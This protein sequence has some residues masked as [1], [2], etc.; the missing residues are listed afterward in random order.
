MNRRLKKDLRISV[1]TLIVTVI[2]STAVFNCIEFFFEKLDT[3]QPTIIFVVLPPQETETLGNEEIN[4]Y[5]EDL[6][7]DQGIVYEVNNRKIRQTDSK[8]LYKRLVESATIR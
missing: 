6:P 5:E 2:V 3:R 1:L 7:E 8:F 4:P